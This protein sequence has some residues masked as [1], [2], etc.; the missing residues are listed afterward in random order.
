MSWRGRWRDWRL[1]QGAAG[2]CGREEP[3][4]EALEA[5]PQHK[6][7]A[8]VPAAQQQQQSAPVAQP[9]ADVDDIAELEKYLAGLE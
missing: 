1:R 8:Q 3:A 4:Q 2:R 5:A 6:P 9:P 7:A